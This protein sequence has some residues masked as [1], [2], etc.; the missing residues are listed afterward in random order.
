MAHRLIWESVHGPIPD[1]MQINH[2]NGVKHDNRISNLELVTPSENT[3]H[4]YAIGLRSA[5]G[6]C[7]G[8]ARLTKDDVLRIRASSMRPADLAASYGVSP[9]TIRDVLSRKRWKHLG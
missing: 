1:G 4:A 6:E 8:R 2:I 7:N 3:K 5:A 9:S